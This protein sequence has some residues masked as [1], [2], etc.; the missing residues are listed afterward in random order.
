[1]RCQHVLTAHHQTTNINLQVED[2]SRVKALAGCL[3]G[4]GGPNSAYLI[5]GT[6]SATG[7]DVAMITKVDPSEPLARAQST[8]R[9]PVP[10]SRCSANGA[11]MQ[12][13]T[14][15]VSKNLYALFDLS[16]SLKV[17]VVGAHLIAFPKQPDRCVRREA[18][19]EVLRRQVEVLLQRG[20]EVAV[21][22]DL[23][24]FD[25]GSVPDI[26]GSKPTSRVLAMLKDPNGDGVDELRS[27]A[28]RIPQVGVCVVCVGGGLLGV[29]AVMCCSGA[30]VFRVMQLIWR[31][32]P[33]FSK[34]S[35]QIH[36]HRPSATQAGT[37]PA[38]TA[39]WTAVA[40]C[41]QR[42]APATNGSAPPAAFVSSA[43]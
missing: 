29:C 24:D 31:N 9:Y 25:D 14:T 4:A 33:I 28:E 11:G 22:G 32:T 37:T 6:D 39:G 30:S 10:G 26:Q 27:V 12:A 36:Q 5:Q 41:A 3:N 42:P 20:Y 2:C 1:V 23:N 43:R 35:S 8:T 21:M 7:Q 17:A 16:P 19:A 34:P 40:A 13:G 18:Q 15:G 38:R